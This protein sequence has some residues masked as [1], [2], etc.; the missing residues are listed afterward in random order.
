MFNTYA[1]RQSIALGYIPANWNQR[2]KQENYYRLYNGL[3][4]FEEDI[5]YV[6]GSYFHKTK[7]IPRFI[8][9]DQYRGYYI[10]TYRSINGV[11]AMINDQPTLITCAQSDVIYVNDTPYHRPTRNDFNIVRMYNG[12]YEF[13]NGDIDIFY[14]DSDGCYH[15]ESEPEIEILPDDDDDDDES[16]EDLLWDYRCGPCLKS[17]M[18][19]DATNDRR[20]FG[21]GIEIEKNAMPDFAFDKREIYAESGAVL[22]YDGSVSNGFELKTPIYNLFSPKTDER[23]EL[24]K[25]FA[26][27]KEV[28]NAGGHIGFSMQGKTDEEL[29]DACSGWLPLIYAMYKKRLGNDYCTAKKVKTLKENKE[30]KYQSIRLRGHYIEFRI[31][32]SVKT[33]ETV[34]F[35]LNFFRILAKNLNKPFSRVLAMAV[36]KNSELYKLLTANYYK[37]SNKLE[38][39]I[40][41][42]IEIN[43]QFGT[44]KLNQ[45]TIDKITQNLAACV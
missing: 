38:R 16:S 37:A 22:E 21:F 13:N 26:N 5:V 43:T 18:Q 30:E 36:D 7:D 1:L 19:I 6:S 10:R 42:A 41:D 31:F 20:Q 9:L 3:Y 32:A 35:R 27:I 17:F 14:W 8:V 25:N 33:F 11:M 24:L 44:R 2:R 12:D 34:K 45:K 23:V 4:A 39:L 29:L 40:K 15:Y 28:D